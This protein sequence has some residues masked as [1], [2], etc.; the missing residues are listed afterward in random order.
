MDQQGNKLVLASASPRRLEILKEAGLSFT[1]RPVEIDEKM[2]SYLS[3]R[4]AVQLLACKKAAA[5]AGK[6]K[7]I[8]IGADTIVVDGHTILGKPADEAEA[9]TMLRQLSGKTHAVLTGVAVLRTA[10]GRM[11]S[12]CEETAV[13]FKALTDAEIEAYIATGEPMDKAGAYGIQGEGGKL[14]LKTEGDFRNVVGLPLQA[15]LQ[16]LEEM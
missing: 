16:L 7:E 13:T 9:F 1:V 4:L 6:E 2:E 8:I 11:C 3:P 15:L 10:D 14:V 12:C 5:A